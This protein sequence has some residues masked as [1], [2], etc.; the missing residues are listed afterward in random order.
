MKRTTALKPSKGKPPT[1]AEKRHY[2]RL[3]E[4]PCL[5]CGRLP[6]ERHHVTGFADRMARTSRRNDRVVPLCAA[7]HRCGAGRWSVESLGHRKFFEI[8]GID[9]MAEA[10]RLWE[11]SQELERK[12]A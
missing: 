11:E 9:L 5:V 6:I 7:H 8:H 4:I 1:A 12:A 3:T 10:E 2:E